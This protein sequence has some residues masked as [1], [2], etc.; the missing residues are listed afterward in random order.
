M[1]LLLTS[2]KD[3]NPHGQI[4][5][6]PKAPHNPTPAT[7]WTG[8]NIAGYFGGGLDSRATVKEQSTAAPI[9]GTLGADKGLGTVS[10]GL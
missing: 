3:E 2:E 9:A 4:I 5:P 10:I 1:R 6:E 8:A 7:A